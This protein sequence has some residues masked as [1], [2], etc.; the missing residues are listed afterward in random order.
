MNEDPKKWINR[1]LSG[2][3]LPALHKTVTDLNALYCE[4]DPFMHLS[5]VILR[6]PAVT[7]HVFTYANS[8]KHQHLGMP[9]TTVEH[10]AMMLG[11]DRMKAVHGKLPVIDP[12]IVNDDQK[13]LLNAYRR[14]YH[15]AVQAS[16][17][18]KIRADMVP[19]EVFAATLMHDLGEM[20]V[21]SFQ[22]DKAL[23]IEKLVHKE[24]HHSREKDQLH[25]LG[26]TYDALSMELVQIW[27]LPLLVHES[28]QQENHSKPRI[29]VILLALEIARLA[30]QSWYSHEM[31]LSIEQAAA[32]LRHSYTEMVNI[33]HQTA[34]TVAR[35]Y[36]TYGVLPV[37]A[38]LI[39]LPP[40]KITKKT[41]IP[42]TSPIEK[43]TTIRRQQQICPEPHPYIFDQTIQKLAGKQNEDKSYNLPAIIGQAI[44]GMY[45]G[46]GLSRV[47]FATCTPDNKG[48]KARVVRSC[49]KNTEFEQFYL[50]LQPANLFTRLMTK[51]MNIRVNDE[52]RIKLG[53]LLPSSLLERLDTDSFFASSLFIDGHPAGLF[54][55]D[56]HLNKKLL[57]EEKYKKF[58]HLCSCAATAIEHLSMTHNRCLAADIIKV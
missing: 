36:Q 47:V 32:L 50:A 48:L 13:G 31:N 56:C 21:W 57:D 29:K 5:D 34:V 15:A 17:W 27:K 26:F 51:P 24:N 11:L 33:V 16:T 54:Y 43:N 6:D 10:A 19:W 42:L 18:A 58:Q 38:R 55:S 25:V 40:P 4:E 7:S 23:E 49:E 52:N 35:T 12:A 14:T 3:T 1:W 28:L 41:D 8:V 20:V 9:V 53:K 2:K 46:I 37:A 22:P 45:E 30:E 44:Q 39:T